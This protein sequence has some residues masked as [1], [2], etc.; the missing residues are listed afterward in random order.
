MC[1]TEEN[2]RGI[3]D[4]YPTFAILN[5][6]RETFHD[7]RKGMLIFAKTSAKIKIFERLSGKQDFAKFSHTTTYEI[8][9]YNENGKKQ[10]P[11]NPSCSPE[12]KASEK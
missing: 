12:V 1:K 7:N 10:F 2:A 6:F 4:L 3:M 11:F 8:S 5:Y 9:H